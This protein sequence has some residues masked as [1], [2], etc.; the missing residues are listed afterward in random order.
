MKIS[1]KQLRESEG[2]TQAE[3]AHILKVSPPAVGL[4]EQ[5]RR[6]P[7][8]D[9]LIKIADYFGVT[10]DYLL[11][12]ETNLN[13]SKHLLANEE[14]RLLDSFRRLPIESKKALMT[15]V[16]QMTTARHTLAQPSLLPV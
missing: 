9:T 3:L 1:L 6:E 15:V 7:D 10:T 16:Q 13:T 11:K 14:T 5:G 4:W 12:R 8:Y 2:I